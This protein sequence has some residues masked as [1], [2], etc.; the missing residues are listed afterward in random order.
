M[1]EKA[2][3]IEKIILLG[4]TELRGYAVT[5]IGIE[6]LIHIQIFT[7]MEAYLFSKGIQKLSLI[8]KMMI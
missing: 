6:F 5:N 2:R 7:P 4:A 3:E 1:H 8:I